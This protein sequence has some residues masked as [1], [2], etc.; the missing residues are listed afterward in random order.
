MKRKDSPSCK[1]PNTSIIVNKL[2]VSGIFFFFFSA[3][4][5]DRTYIFFST[6]VQLL[7]L[8]INLSQLESKKHTFESNQ[9]KYKQQQLPKGKKQWKA[10]VS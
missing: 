6:D 1:R 3:N 2:P 10:Q 8:N 5:P 9:N 7:S 4:E